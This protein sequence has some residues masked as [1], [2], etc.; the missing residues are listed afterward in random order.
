MAPGSRVQKSISVFIPA[1]IFGCVCF[2]VFFTYLLQEF[3]LSLFSM[4]METCLVPLRLQKVSLDDAREKRKR[5]TPKGSTIAKGADHF[6][7]DLRLS[8]CKCRWHNLTADS[9]N[10]ITLHPPIHQFQMPGRACC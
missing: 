1:L 9:T 4:L 5:D 3:R 10:S 6:T 8:C 7:A 2:L